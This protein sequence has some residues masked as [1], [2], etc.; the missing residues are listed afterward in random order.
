MELV[1]WII[2]NVIVPLSPVPLVY[3]GAWLVRAPKRLT[4]IVRD[5][6]M[7]FYCTALS[8]SCINDLVK[9]MESGKIQQTAFHST[10]GIAIAGAISCMILSTFTYAVATTASERTGVDEVKLAVASA[11]TTLTT[12]AIVAST[13]FGLGI[14]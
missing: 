3:L 9:A 7:C 10:A 13:R 1:D 2:F 5:G 6:Q 8:A 11:A 14:I 4:T 12:V